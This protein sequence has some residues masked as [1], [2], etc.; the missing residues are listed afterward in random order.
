MA[1]ALIAVAHPVHAQN[2]GNAMQIQQVGTFQHAN[3]GLTA[4]EYSST[5]DWYLDADMGPGHWH[6]WIEAA[7]TPQRGGITRAYPSANADVGTALGGDGEGRVQVSELRYGLTLSPTTTLYMGLMDPTVFLDTTGSLTPGIDD[8]GIANNETRQFL[9]APFVNNPSIDFP[10]Y[11]LGAV[12]SNFAPHSAFGGQLMIAS[13]N[14]LADNPRADYGQLFDVGARHKGV[15]AAGEGYVHD[16]DRLFARLGA[17]TNSHRHVGA[18]GRAL[19][20]NYGAYAV[21]DGR[22]SDRAGLNLRLGW[23]NPRVSNTRTF[24]A[25]AGE[26]PIGSIALGA[27]IAR[28]QVSDTHDAP[29]PDGLQSEVY[30]RIPVTAYLHISPDIQYIAH[31]AGAGAERATAD[32][33]VVYGLRVKLAFPP[34]S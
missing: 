19:G 13:S 5:A 7:T 9:A 31:L 22:A 11:T 27:A 28:S 34:D 4:D 3:D 33:V 2:N 18:A 1:L 24:A 8:A 17:W 23:A 26:A 10:D 6:A 14:G 29:T 15:F 25:V 30:A 16:G 21:I 20:H 32:H 12:L